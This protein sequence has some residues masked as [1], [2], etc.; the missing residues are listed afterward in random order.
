MNDVLIIVIA[1][2]A[3]QFLIVH[4]RFLLACA[5]ATG[6]LVWIAQSEL[7]AVARP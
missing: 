3:A 6:D 7:P 4:L 2:S 1:Q 5:P